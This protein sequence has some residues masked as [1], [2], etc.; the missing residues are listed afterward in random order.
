MALGST[1][2]LTEMSTRSISWGV[3]RPVRKAD[4]LPSSCAVVMKSG[5]LNFLEAFTPL[6][7]CNGTAL[8]FT[9]TSETSPTE[10]IRVFPCIET[11]FFL[12]LEMEYI[13]GA[14]RRTTSLNSVSLEWHTTMLFPLGPDIPTGTR[15]QHHSLSISTIESEMNYSMSLNES[16]VTTHMA[17]SSFR[18]YERCFGVQLR[19]I[20]SLCR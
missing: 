17:A 7:A 16:L 9:F 14:V 20:V 5:N 8:P 11:F 18:I 3:K 10:W 19:I 13:Y 12:V 1:Q 2:S 4:N 6:R 15:S